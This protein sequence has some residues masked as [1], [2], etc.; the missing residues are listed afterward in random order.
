MSISR[1][2]HHLPWMLAVVVAHIVEVTT[3][4]I[5]PTAPTTS[6]TVLTIIAGRRIRMPKIKL[7]DSIAQGRLNICEVKHCLAA[8]WGAKG[9]GINIF[10]RQIMTR[11]NGR[12]V[13]RLDGPKLNQPV[14]ESCP[15]WGDLVIDLSGASSA[16]CTQCDS[17][18]TYYGVSW[19]WL[20]QTWHC[21]HGDLQHT[22]NIQ[23]G[24]ISQCSG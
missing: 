14:A 20:T 9:T 3:F 8:G 18:S 21:C 6:G 10:R 4:H 19:K 11:N 2:H 22:G 15:I 13:R 7:N 23:E 24:S 16:T 5:T 12:E 1:R 17:G